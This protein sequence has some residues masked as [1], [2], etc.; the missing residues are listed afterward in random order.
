MLISGTASLTACKLPTACINFRHFPTLGISN[1][2]ALILRAER[3][4]AAGFNLL[5]TYTWAKFLNNT[6]EGG[7]ALG[8]TGV[9]SDYYNRRLDY[10]PSAND[11]RHR[12]TISSVYELPVGRGK[13]YLAKHWS[14]RVVGDWSLS[15][16]AL[17]QSGPP[18][19]V[20][21]QTNTTNAFSAGAQ[22]ADLLRDPV[23]PNSERT[24]SRW[25]DTSPLDLCATR[26]A[27]VWHGRA[28]NPA[29]AMERSLSIFQS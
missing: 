3:R 17:L 8:N 7:A 6:D 11:I 25:F 26:G 23:L 12:V 29:R 22:R 4:F 15:M 18:F 13:R 10:G 21:T 27:H 16:L 28:R 9:Y 20:T 2:H 19:T 5:S 14:G 1:Y 24:L